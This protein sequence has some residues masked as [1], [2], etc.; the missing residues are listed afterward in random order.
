MRSM[1]CATCSLPWTYQAYSLTPLRRE[2]C[3]LPYVVIPALA[4]LAQLQG[5]DSRPAFLSFTT[6][7]LHQVAP[8]P[9]VIKLA[10]KRAVL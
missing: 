7:L 5:R 9:W 2:L 3:F 4:R 8:N 6:G 1:L 10:N